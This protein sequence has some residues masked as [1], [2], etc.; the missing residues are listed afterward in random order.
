VDTLVLWAIVPVSRRLPGRPVRP[1]NLSSAM[2]VELPVQLEDPLTRLSA[3]AARTAEQKSR[4]VA[5]ATAAVVRMADH[6]PAALFAA[7]A[8]AYGRAGQGRVNVVASNVPGPAGVRYLAGRRVLEMVPYVPV[9]EEIRATAA[10]LTYAG[11]LTVAITG[12]ADSLPDVH[13]LVDAVGQE[14]ADLV[15]APAADDG[16]SRRG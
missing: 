9:A 16:A 14:L 15:G 1:G 6:V 7:G 12:D 8:R 13:R 5:D 3:V 2:F 4:E 11:R 10:A